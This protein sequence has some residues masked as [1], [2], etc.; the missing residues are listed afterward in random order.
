MQP[1]AESSASTEGRNLRHL[2][3]W[4]RLVLRLFGAVAS[5]LLLSMAF[6]PV[7]FPLFVFVA[8]I[9]LLLIPQPP[10]FLRRLGLGWIFGFAY[11]VANFSWLNTIGFGAGFLMALAVACYPMLWYALFGSLLHAW[12]EER[13]DVRPNPGLGGL[14]S[15]LRQVGAVLVG[16]ALW[17]GLEWL[18]SWLFTGFPWNFLGVALWQS[19]ALLRVCP[20]TGVYGLSF[21]VAAV[22]LSL[23]SRLHDFWRAYRTGR[24]AG[25]SWPFAVLIVLFLLLL[26]T[27]WLVSPLPA[28][29]RTVS[30]LAVQGNIPQCRE[31]SEEDFRTTLGIY[32]ELTRAQAPAGAPDL[33]VWPETAVPAPLGHPPYLAAVKEL[34][35]Y[36][37][38][39]LL[40]GTVDYRPVSMEGDAEDDYLSFNSAILLDENAQP[41]DYYDKIHRVPF[42]EYVPFS[43]HLPWLVD[44]IGMGRDLTPGTEYTVFHLPKGVR[45]GVNICFEDAFPGISRAFV[46]RGANVLM[47]ITNDAWYAESSGSRQHLIQAVFRAAETRRPLLRSGN[48]SDTCLILPDGR[49]T[50]LLSDPET[51]SPFYRGS[52]IY[53]VPVWDDPPVTFYTRHG[54]WFAILCALV[55]AGAIVW[56]AQNAYRQRLAQRV[57]RLGDTAA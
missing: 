9:P 13:D 32:T 53:D 27:R 26:S 49:V 55:S 16:A 33:V 52:R 48:N 28:P 6:P 4:R 10:T 34:Q 41:I 44:W 5:G 22:N 51:G 31:W 1:T 25:R 35:E 37:R 39:P 40:L 29:D 15:P 38:T 3:G 7:E 11:A 24:P 45:A 56:L 46:Q 47:T 57:A 43:R 12:R 14:R 8:L 2:V 42:G 19:P 23:A 21:L 54:D 50:D 18:R 20:F 36:T 17:V 30:V